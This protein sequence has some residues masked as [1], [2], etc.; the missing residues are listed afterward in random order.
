MFIN[1]SPDENDAV[2]LRKEE[3]YVRK[4]VVDSQE[5]PGSFETDIYKEHATAIRNEQLLEPCGKSK[6]E[7]SDLY[8]NHYLLTPSDNSDKSFN[9]FTIAIILYY[10]RKWP[11]TCAVSFV[12]FQILI[13]LAKFFKTCIDYSTFI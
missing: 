5:N 11:K 7:Q 6:V 8:Y 2:H 4:E 12:I 9:M 10:C 13:T 3:V 1:A